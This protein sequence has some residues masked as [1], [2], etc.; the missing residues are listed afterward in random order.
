[1]LSFQME[2]NEIRR[3]WA[4]IVYEEEESK[5]SRAR[6]FGKGIFNLVHN[7]SALNWN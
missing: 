2:Q 5:P 7:T 4:T 3:S 1:M 6:Y